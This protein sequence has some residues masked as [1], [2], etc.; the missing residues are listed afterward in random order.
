MQSFS[1]G[2]NQPSNAHE[3]LGNELRQLLYTFVYTR[4]NYKL[5]PHLKNIGNCLLYS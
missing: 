1:T 4:V 3:L 2:A 5:M